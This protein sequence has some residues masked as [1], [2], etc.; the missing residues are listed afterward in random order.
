[1]LSR[2][3]IDHARVTHG[4]PF[5]AWWAGSYLYPT[6]VPHILVDCSRCDEARAQRDMLGEYRRWVLT[7]LLHSKSCHVSVTDTVQ[8]ATVFIFCMFPL[9][10]RR[11]ISFVLDSLTCH[12]AM[13]ALL[14]PLCTVLPVMSADSILLVLQCLVLKDI[15]I[16]GPF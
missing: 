8:A 12:T 4:W 9:R 11:D 1:M 3:R 2:F 15:Y 13:P 16:T 10:R 5:A 7:C 6:F 14:Q